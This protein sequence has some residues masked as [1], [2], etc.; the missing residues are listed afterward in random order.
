MFVCKQKLITVRVCVC[1]PVLMV[2]PSCRRVGR[3][4]TQGPWTGACSSGGLP[5]ES[6]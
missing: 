1:V 3:G 6:P 4:P 2:N 5:D